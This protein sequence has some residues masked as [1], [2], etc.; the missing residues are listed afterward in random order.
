MRETPSIAQHC[1]STRG[2]GAPF[3]AQAGASGYC[4][5]HDPGAMEARRRGGHPKNRAERTAKPLPARLQPKVSL[6]EDALGG[7]HRGELAPQAAS[8]MASLAGAL[9]RAMTAGELEERLRALEDRGGGKVS[10]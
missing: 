8:A 10:S 3:T 6:L 2:D 4:I 7:V 1:V 9:V 5:G